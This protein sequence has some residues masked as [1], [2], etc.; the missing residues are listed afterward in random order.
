LICSKG[1]QETE[2]TA[3]P[4]TCSPKRELAAAAFSQINPLAMGKICRIVMPKGGRRGNTGLK[5]KIHRSVSR[6][7]VKKTITRDRT[8]DYHGVDKLETKIRGLEEEETLGWVGLT[9]LAK[10]A[11]MKDLKNFRAK[12]MIKDVKHDR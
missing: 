11:K 2:R 10:K 6:P 9:A 4:F 12:L 5:G 8:V 1:K 3:A 7:A